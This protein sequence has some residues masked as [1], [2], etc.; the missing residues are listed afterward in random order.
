M[1]IWV[2]TY[3]VPILV[4]ER[5]VT[6]TMDGG[7]SWKLSKVIT[8]QLKNAGL[9]VSVIVLV[10]TKIQTCRSS[11]PFT[12][13]VLFQVLVFFLQSNY[14]SQLVFSSLALFLLS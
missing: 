5:I 1:I 9:P 13:P 12:S 11:P 3:P 14:R 6:I 2:P 8:Y 10:F 4:P 7:K